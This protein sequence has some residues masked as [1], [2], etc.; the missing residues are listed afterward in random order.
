[1]PGI[2]ALCERL[3]RITF[4]TTDGRESAYCHEHGNLIY[5]NAFGRSL[6]LAFSLNYTYR[7]PAE[8]SYTSER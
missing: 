3:S 4:I 8:P 1:M 5:R 7:L 2:C 6:D